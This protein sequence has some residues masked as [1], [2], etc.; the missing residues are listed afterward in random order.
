MRRKVLSALLA[1]SLTVGGTVYVPVKNVTAAEEA[2]YKYITM[3]VPYTDFYEVY[4]LTDKAVWEVEDGI[5]AV[6]TATT[7]KFKGTTGLAKGTYNDGTYIMGVTIPVAVSEEGYNELKT[8][9]TE[10]DNYYFTDLEEA[11]EYYSEL[12]VVDGVYSFSKIQDTKIDTSYLSVPED[13]FT[14]V[15]G[16]GDYQITLGGVTTADGIQIGEDEFV[17]Y[18]I[19]GAILNTTDGNSYGMTALEN[20][21]YG[22]RIDEVEIAWSVIGGQGLKRAH[23]RGD[24]YYQFDMN[25]ATLSSVTLIT[26]LGVIDISCGEDGLKLDEYY[27]GDLSKLAFSIAADSDVLTISGVPEDLADVTVSVSG[28][29][30]TKAE[31]VDNKVQLSSNPVDGT[32]YTVTINSSNFPAISKTV[33]TPISEAQKVELQKWIDKAEAVEGYDSDS[34]LQ[35]HVQ[36]AKDL[37]VNVNATSV[38]AAELIGELVGKVKKYYSTAT[39]T[40]TLK[41]SVLKITLDVSI[42]ELDSPTYTLTYKAGRS[43]ATLTGGDLNALTQ[44]LDKAPTV[45]TEYTLT[46][47]SD[48]YQDITVSVKAEAEEVVEPSTEEPCEVP[49]EAPSENVTTKAPET[50]ATP[51]TT[52]APATT[53]ADANVKKPAKVTGVTAKKSGK[54]KIKVTWKKAKNVKGYQIQYATNKNFKKAKSVTVKKASATNKLIKKLKANKT[55]YVRVRAYTTKSGKNLYG[56]WSAKKIVKAK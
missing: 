37:I 16:Y 24:K 26:D 30:A 10:E 47:V 5:D 25:G 44:T 42:E 7:T 46:I 36:E 14:L 23:G 45:D 11:P 41:G 15:G 19:Y 33:S 4:N 54:K 12:T 27:T 48:N 28:N 38:E 9:L 35:E 43:S 31:I 39:A 6:S 51:A 17:D 2:S 53:D 52:A 49:T 55:Y 29:L 50:T 8:D 3:N 21:W 56:V 34:D 1:L 18:T 22:T 20:L 40:A 13:E 32:N